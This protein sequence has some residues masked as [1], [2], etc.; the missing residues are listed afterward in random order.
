MLKISKSLVAKQLKEP[1]FEPPPELRG[2]DDDRA[3]RTRELVTRAW[4]GLWR[5][6]R[7][8]DFGTARRDQ[9]L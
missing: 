5:A 6:D 3:S 2:S 1:Y 4:N 7:D 9:S 8:P